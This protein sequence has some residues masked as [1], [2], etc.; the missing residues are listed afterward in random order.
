MNV[1]DVAAVVGVIRDVLLIFFMAGLIWM[2]LNLLAR[3]QDAATP[4][5]CADAPQFTEG[6]G[7]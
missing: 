4:Q 6:C 2:G 5:P 3:V 7:S 1:R